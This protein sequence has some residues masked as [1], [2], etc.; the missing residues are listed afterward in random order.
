[1]E[2][3]NLKRLLNHRIEELGKKQKEL[4]PIDTEIIRIRAR[5]K[6]LERLLGLIEKENNKSRTISG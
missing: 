6:E 5:R 3:K 4:S 2:T 1:M